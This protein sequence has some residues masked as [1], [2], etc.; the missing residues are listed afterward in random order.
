MTRDQLIRAIHS[1]AL[2][3]EMNECRRIFALGQISYRIY[4]QILKEATMNNPQKG[5]TQ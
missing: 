1:A 2:R 4:K 3:G 5:Q